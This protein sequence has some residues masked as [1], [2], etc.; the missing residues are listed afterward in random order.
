MVGS[1][2]LLLLIAVVGNLSIISISLL[3]ASRTAS[4]ELANGLL[5]LISFPM[6]LLSEL[7]FSLDD[8]PAWLQD[9][10]QLLPLTHLVKAA[11]G[12]MLEGDGILQVSP[13][14][15]ILVLMTVTCLTLAGWL[16]R[17]RD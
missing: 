17:W 2:L 3:M 6:L 13:Q 14:L 10:S 4:E 9:I 5:N 11:R 1:Y 12:V 16:F 8:A 7:W 15:L